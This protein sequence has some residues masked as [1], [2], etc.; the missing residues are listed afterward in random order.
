MALTRFVRSRPPFPPAAGRWLPDWFDQRGR[1]RLD[2]PDWSDWWSEEGGGL[3]VEEFEDGD[4]FVV[5]VEVPGI[6]PDEDVELTVSDHTLRLRVERRAE[7]ETQT[8]DGYRSEFRYGAYTRTIP[9]P[10][11]AGDEDIAATYNDGILEVRVPFDK[12]GS[13]AQKIPISRG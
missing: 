9:L 6:D 7:E 10:S 12:G 3:K 1:D 2:W 11:G 5:R 13:T 8:K 4:R